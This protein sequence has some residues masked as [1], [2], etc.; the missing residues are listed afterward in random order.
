MRGASVFSSRLVSILCAAL[1]LVLI[2]ASIALLRLEFWG[3][4]KLILPVQSPVNAQSL[5]GLSFVLTLLFRG[6]N[7]ANEST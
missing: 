3:R 1:V 6:E 2:G 5:I 7:R 4:F